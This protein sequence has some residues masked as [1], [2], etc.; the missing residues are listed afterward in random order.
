MFETTNVLKEFIIGTAE[1]QTFMYTGFKLTQDDKGITLDQTDYV[2]NLEILDLDINR[3]RVKM[4]EMT[5][6]ELTCLRRYAGSLNWAVG[7]SRPD[8]SFDMI[9]LSTHFKGGNVSALKQAHSVMKALKKAPAFLRISNLG[10]LNNCQ[11]W[12]FSDAAH[13]NLN[14][15]TDSAGGYITFIVNIKDGN[16]APIEWRSNK[17]KRKVSSTLAAEMLAL[18]NALEAAIGTRD[19]IYEMSAGKI[20]LKIKAITDNKSARDAIYSEKAN[21]QKR[22]RA[23]IAGIKETI[24]N[25][26]IEEIKWVAGQYMLADILT[27]KGVKRHNL[28]SVL[29]QGK[30]GL[31]L[32]K[33]CST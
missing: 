19:Q 29:Q 12:V 17:I 2:E 10:N 30:I 18:S 14:N 25:G 9:S 32:I 21:D 27:K 8:L 28:M 24:D 33:I 31:D 20:N 4:S 6:T 22:L 3:L 16:C 26:E 11:L 13:R 1:E 5:Q 15:N 7:I 23:E